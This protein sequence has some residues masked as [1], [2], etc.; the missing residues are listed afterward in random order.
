[1]SSILGACGLNCSEC[2]GYKATQSND[3][4]A[5]AKVSAQWS[6]YFNTEIKPEIVY[7][8][9]C[10][11]KGSRKSGFCFK[12]EVRKCVVSKSIPNC[13]YCD[14]YACEILTEFF[15][16]APCIQGR[17]NEIRAELGKTDNE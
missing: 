8:D 16:E 2:I 7:C 9:G 17:L 11:T 14:D 12:C 6:K 3:P 4:E 1:M 15:K 5:I 10:M 13:A